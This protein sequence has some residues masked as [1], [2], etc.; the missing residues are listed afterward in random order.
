MF[1]SFAFSLW[2]EGGCANAYPPYENVYGS[3]VGQVSE[4]HL[5]F[6]GAI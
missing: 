5:P 3:F 6:P 4:A 2:L 1:L